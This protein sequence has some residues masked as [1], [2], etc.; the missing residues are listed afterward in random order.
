MN[1]DA[2]WPGQIRRDP[3]GKFWIC[4]DARQDY[5]RWVRVTGN[6]KS[7][8]VCGDSYAVQW[9][10]VNESHQLPLPHG[11]ARVSPAGVVWQKTM[12]GTEWTNTLDNQTVADDD[13]RDFRVIWTPEECK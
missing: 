6:D 13:V 2:M 7:S 9:E 4:T 5:A 3:T 10:I 8:S 11:Q 1:R 12:S